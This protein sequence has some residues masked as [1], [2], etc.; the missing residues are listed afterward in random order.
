MKVSEVYIN[1]TR[2]YR[3]GES[4]PYEPYTDNIGKL[5][6]SYQREFGRCTSKVYVD[7]DH[8]PKAIGWVFVKKMRY[9][10]ARSKND[11]YVR[12]VWVTV[13]EKD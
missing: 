2:G 9:E 13:H 5:F 8:G 10:D 12:E 1:A 3:F 6:L 11:T 4:E 7:T